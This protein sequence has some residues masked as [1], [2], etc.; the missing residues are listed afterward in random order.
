V[1]E[2]P[3]QTDV[4]AGS[5]LLTPVQQAIAT[6]RT[7]RARLQAAEHRAVAPVAIIGMSCRF[8]G[9]DDLGAFWRLLRDGVDAVGEIPADRWDVDAWYDPDPQAPGK[10]STRHGGFLRDI[11]DFDA[12]FFGISDREAVSVDPQHRLMLEGAREAL[13]DAGLTHEALFGSRTGVFVGI[14]SFD[15]ASLRGQRGDFAQLDAYHAAGISH[16]AAAGRLAYYLGLQGPAI[17]IDTAC[18]SSLVAIHLACQALRLGD[19]GA[20]LAGGV[21]LILSPEL[22][23][24]LTKARMLAPDGRCKAFAAGADGFVR[25]E[26]C[27]IV[28]LKLLDEAMRDGD[29]IHAVIRGSACNQDGR[30]SGLSA[31]NGPAQTAVVRAAWK[32]AGVRPEQID[33]VEAH[34]TGTGLGD[35]IEAGALAAAFADAAKTHLLGIGSVKSNLGHMEAAAGVGGVIK[36]VLALKNESL[37]ASL[38][39][40]TLSPE[41]DWEACGLKVIAEAT[42][43]PRQITPRFAGVSSFGFSGTNVHIVLEEAPLSPPTPDTDSA[44]RI[45]TIS[46]TDDGALRRAAE[47]FGD[48]LTRLGREPSAWPD[49]TYTANAGRSHFA[50]RAAVVAGSPA[51]A[52]R[53]LAALAAGPLGAGPLGAGPLGA[54][55]GCAGLARGRVDRMHEPSVGFLAGPSVADLAP[56][57][58]Q[59]ELYRTS[60]AFRAAVDACAPWLG[61]GPAP[62]ETAA[63]DRFA[64]AT[65]WAL[66][67][68]WLAWGLSPSIVMGEGV[69]AYVAACIAGVLTLQDAMTLVAL[70]AACLDPAGR[71]PRRAE[72]ASEDFRAALA[73]AGVS[74]PTLALWSSALR[75]TFGP[76]DI[77]AI[78]DWL[79]AFDAPFDH[80]TDAADAGAPCPEVLLDLGRNRIAAPERP[81]AEGP[82]DPPAPE[83]SLRH[84]MLVALS[85]LYVRGA[86]IDWRTVEGPRPGRAVDV[87]G[88]PWSRRRY[89]F[90]DA[91]TTGDWAPAEASWQAILAD[92]GRQADQIPI[93]LL[94]HTYAEKYRRLGA[95]AS[96]YIVRTL[97]EL[98]AFARPGEVLTSD[99]IIRSCGVLP[100]YRQLLA[101]WM[102]RLADQGRLARL[103]A[104]FILSAP[105]TTVPVTALEAEAERVFTDSPMLLDYV[106]GCG[107]LLTPILRGATS[108]L[109]T[110]FPGGKFELAE[111]I[112]HR[113]P[114]SRY[115][116]ALAAEAARSFVSGRPGTVR[117]LEVG[118]GTGG[119]TGAILPR[120]PADRATYTFTDVSPFF[121]DAAQRRFSGFQ[122]VPD[123]DV[124]D[125]ERSPQAQGFRAGAYDLIVAA[126]VLHATARLDQTLDFVRG[127]LAPGG[128]L[129]LYEVTDPPAY[130]DVSIALIEGWQTASDDIRGDGPLLNTEQWKRLLPRHGFDRVEAWPS[131]DSPANVLGSRVFMA[132]ADDA[133]A[134]SSAASL[135]RDSQ[136]PPRHAARPALE[137]EAA[138]DIRAILDQAP[139]SEHREILIQ[140]VRRIVTLVLRRT[141]T[142]EIAADQRLMDL[143]LDSLMAVELRNNLTQ[144]LRLTQN[145]PATLMFDHPS[146]G[147]IADFL[148]ER[149]HPEAPATTPE[150]KLDGALGAATTG[151][152]RTTAAQLAALSDAEVESL[153]NRKLALL[154]QDHDE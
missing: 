45:L 26:G 40:K 58:R 115:F 3:V 135:A 110:L 41:I 132:R 14:S 36:T 88:H 90:P 9:A 112:Y 114:L 20:A 145:L 32:A 11:A 74:A 85:E 152:V 108:P 97:V 49:F 46:G 64:F 39:C 37:P 113:A 96:A 137:T 107:A 119:V 143:G 60:E 84:G 34:G 80:F 53:S 127:L 151:A 100:L 128:A 124:L 103:D 55:E 57:P 23:V 27:G 89:W 138:E 129:L 22:H 125:L 101:V 94:L 116:N 154:S 59:D 122:T 83:P 147:A 67:R 139:R 50:A 71:A 76:G 102:G 69:G 86:P 118:G 47:R 70:R 51:D 149:L 121:F 19:C 130:F 42:P 6:I 30:S 131:S 56:D 133:R 126:N 44:C 68:T 111:A 150:P 72:R 79:N 82:R 17:A 13:D 61:G 109:D 66:A 12:E 1:S 98:G 104:G 48:C 4:T 142:R 93:D 87:P 146:I 63:H 10:M 73:A 95:L 120:L 81:Q 31:P 21:N 117:I 77:V 78:A 15:Y 144:G 18:S 29:R 35:P 105:L 16:S 8:P 43:W 65:Q 5:A 140:F 52:A 91:A 75:R 24:T 7:L 106:K 38:H 62:F 33:Y 141:A 54:G 25:S 134:G 136:A 2:A 148:F 92:T 123:F 153:L 28:V 99:G